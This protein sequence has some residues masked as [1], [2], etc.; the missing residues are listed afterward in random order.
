M[1]WRLYLILQC[2][3]GCSRGDDSKTSGRKKEK[4]KG[5][6]VRG[7]SVFQDKVRA[8]G[9]RGETANCLAMR[10]VRRNIP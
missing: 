1:I 9:D 10:T 3:G 4:T 5:L 6:T 8:L 2:K 7:Q